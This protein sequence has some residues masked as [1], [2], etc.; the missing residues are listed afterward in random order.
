MLSL[1]AVENA[2][3]SVLEGL[4]KSLENTHLTKLTS[5]SDPINLQIYDTCQLPSHV[6]SSYRFFDGLLLA[7]PL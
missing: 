6:T 2:V 7:H 5:P 3:D 1:P 4:T